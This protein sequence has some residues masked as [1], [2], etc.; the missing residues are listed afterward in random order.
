MLRV[1]TLDGAPGMAGTACSLR[2]R[3]PGRADWGTLLDSN[4]CCGQ[5]NAQKST[6]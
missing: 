2:A 3:F 4:L 6:S 5:T 1:Q